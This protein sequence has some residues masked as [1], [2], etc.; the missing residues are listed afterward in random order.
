V[1]FAQLTHKS[2]TSSSLQPLAEVLA[3]NENV[4]LV[5]ESVFHGA[6]SFAEQ[7]SN[8]STARRADGYID[9][10]ASEKLGRPGYVR[11]SFEVYVPLWLVC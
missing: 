11:V 4:G 9:S 3:E 10:D 8:K 6:H 2:F 7:Y 5:L 1:K